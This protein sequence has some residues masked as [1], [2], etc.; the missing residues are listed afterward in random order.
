MRLNISP[1]RLISDVQKDFNS[2]FPFLK[3]QFFQNRAFKPESSNSNL[4]PASTNIGKAQ[5]ELHEGDIEINGSMKVNELE[6]I[7]ND[8]YSLKAQIF[9][10]SGTI[11]LETTMTDNWTL[12]QQNEHGRE[13]STEKP[14]GT[15]RSGNDYELTRD[16]DH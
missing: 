6:K 3:I 8:E 4:I 15:S 5:K 7:L 9:R 10:L 1:S 16:A 2:E 11:W 14:P 12:S 13:I